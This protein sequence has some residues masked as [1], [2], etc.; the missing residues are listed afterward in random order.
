MV[1]ARL[2]LKEDNSTAALL[3]YEKA[4]NAV[5]K[6]TP[7]VSYEVLVFTNSVNQREKKIGL[8][9]ENTR[10]FVERNPANKE[11]LVTL[12]QLAFQSGEAES[13]FDAI[14]KTLNADPHYYP[15]R[16]LL[17]RVRTRQGR[18]DL[19]EEQLRILYDRYPDSVGTLLPLAE[20]L[21]LQ[22]RS[23][24]SRDF[25]V[26]VLADH[27]KNGS[28]RSLLLDSYLL[29]SKVDSA[30]WVLDGWTQANPEMDL[31]IQIRKARIF[32]LANRPDQAREALTPY[33]KKQESNL[34]AFAELAILHAKLGAYDSA[35]LVYQQ[36]T[37]ITAAARSSVEPLMVFLYLKVQNPARALESLLR[38]Q[39]GNRRGGNL[40]LLLAAHVATGQDNKALA[41]IASQP[42]SARPGLESFLALLPRDKEFI[43]QWALVNFFSANRMEHLAMR[44]AE[45]LHRQWPGSDLAKLLY[46]NKLAAGR[47]N[48]DAAKVLEG[49]GNPSLRQKLNLIQ[50][51]VGSRNAVKAVALGEK[52]LSENPEL[53]GI[54]LML[55]D[56]AWAANDKAK[57]IARYERELKISPDNPTAL[58]NLAWEYGIVQKDL[59]KARIYLEKLE[60][61]K[62]LDP[63]IMDTIG[64]ILAKNGSTDKAEAYLRN[65][66]DIVPDHPVFHYHLAYTLH[67]LGRKEE[68]RKHLDASLSSKRPFDERKE[69][70]ALR[71]EQG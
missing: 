52:I 11:G 55:A 12:A 10:K 47:R 3:E 34:P 9:L 30:Q 2:Y 17:T 56:F 8:A 40:S 6:F 23:A 46:S 7:Y 19:A 21:L 50:L 63:R 61:H 36:M 54:N 66:L 41:L 38:M 51:Y 64:W 29:E 24:E 22:G 4:Y 58:N 43:G 62:R 49:L 15:A 37:D 35:I 33:L 31:P 53:P 18:L 16:L 70:E 69:A 1:K 28:A 60:K 13:A 39:I 25:L 26:R 65:A 44:E 20:N 57:G 14:N 42:D 59:T 45:K 5:G 32:A 71:A 27:P 67:V 68:A 48:A